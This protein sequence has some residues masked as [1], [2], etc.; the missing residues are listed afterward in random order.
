MKSMR[1]HFSR[2]FAAGIVALL[3]IVG[4]VLTVVYLETQIAGPWLREQ[5]YYFFGCGLLL[6][7]VLIYAIGLVASTFLGKWVWGRFD[8][9][10]NELPVLGRLYQTLKQILGYGEG[11][12]AM[13]RRVVMVPARDLRAEEVGLVTNETYALGRNMLTVFL[14]GSPNP[15]TGRVVI[16]DAAEAR[17]L[18]VS[19]KDVLTSLVSVGALSLEPVSD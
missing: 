10:V 5:G 19:V 4:T 7:L 16:V 6:A 1:R 14:P 18:D 17:A 9:I 11:P 15:T 13:F 3:P 12:D 2:C 8:S